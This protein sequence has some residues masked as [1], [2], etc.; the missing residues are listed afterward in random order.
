MIS[1]PK[2]TQQLMFFSGVGGSAAAAHIFVV[3][4]CVTYLNIE[5][6]IANVIAFFIAFNISYLGHKYVTF[7]YRSD[8]KQLSL[9]HFFLVASS[10][11]VLNEVLYFV[12]LNYTSIHYLVA[13]ILDLG[14]VAIYS[15]LLSH[16]WACR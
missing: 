4:N 9:P 10:A 6:L 7:S 1:I 3:L 14:L 12:L 5:P 2:A 8:Q 16:F 15:F 11:G 13:L